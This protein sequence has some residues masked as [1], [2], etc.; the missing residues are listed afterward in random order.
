[1][2]MSVNNPPE[3]VRRSERMPSKSVEAI[4][5]VQAANEAAGININ[6]NTNDRTNAI[7]TGITPF[8]LLYADE[9]AYPEQASFRHTATCSH[10]N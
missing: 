3:A 7:N 2:S 9:S 4:S 5:G 6:I 10:R 1:M 8:K